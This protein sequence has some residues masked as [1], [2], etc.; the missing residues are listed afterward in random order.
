[1]KNYSFEQ[2]TTK[3]EQADW[4][5]FYECENIEEAWDMLYTKFL[6]FLDENCPETVFNNVPKKSEWLTAALLELMKSTLSITILGF[7]IRQNM[8]K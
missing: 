3:V 1:M 6:A 8:G 4:T 7:L 2:L 5:E